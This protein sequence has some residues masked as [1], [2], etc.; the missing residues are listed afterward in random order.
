MNHI[1]V[2]FPVTDQ[3]SRDTLMAMLSTL[4]FTGFE[5]TEDMLIAYADEQG[6]DEAAVQEIAGRLQ[7]GF[8]TGQIAQ[9]NWN[10]EWEKH[11]QP[12]IID[13]FCSVRADFHPRPENISYDIVI[14]PKMSFGTGHHATTALMMTFMREINLQD[15][16]VF[17]F[18]TGTGILAILAEMLGAR[19][20]LA[21]DNDE[22]SFE[23]AQE[24]CTRNAATKVTV[25]MGTADD[26]PAASTFDIVLANINRHILL[27]YMDRMAAMLRP[28]GTLLLSGILPEDIAM[29]R[30]EAASV[31]FIY[32]QERIERNWAC[33]QFAQKAES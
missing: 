27:A 30:S 4:D 2:S 3:D 7:L 13:G 9:R 12:V 1:K 28:G 19:S 26:L 25:Q 8:S 31:G 10:E 23:N 16:D 24:N 33:L 11:F 14:T 18:G 15:K 21:I 6:Y 29:I 17:D 20:V 32:Q 22:W 5:E